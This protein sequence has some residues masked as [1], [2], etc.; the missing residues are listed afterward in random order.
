MF[1]IQARDTVGVYI[2]I[3]F[4][5]YVHGLM[6]SLAPAQRLG[7]AGTLNSCPLAQAHKWYVVALVAAES[8]T[9]GRPRSVT[10]PPATS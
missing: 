4:K 6:F 3:I 5:S 9:V 8:T 1:L 2:I 7:L 10:P